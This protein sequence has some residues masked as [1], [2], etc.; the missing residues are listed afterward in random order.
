MSLLHTTNLID[1]YGKPMQNSIG[2]HVTKMGDIYTIYIYRNSNISYNSD[3]YI[4]YIDT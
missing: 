3:E 1:F 2:Y 4:Y